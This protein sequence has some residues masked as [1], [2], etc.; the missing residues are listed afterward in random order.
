MRD[1]EGQKLEL[2]FFRNRLGHEVDFVLLRDRK[3]WLAIEAKMGDWHLAPGLVYFVERVQPEHAF[4][5]VLGE[6]REAKLPDIG[7]TR[8]RVVSARRLL[9]NLP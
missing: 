6:G 9:A 5:V 2:R 8:V 7:R 4:Q 3:P 1:V